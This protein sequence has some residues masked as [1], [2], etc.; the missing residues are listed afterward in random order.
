MILAML[1]ILVTPSAD[2]RLFNVASPQDLVK[3]SKLVFVGRVSSVR[4]SGIST[5]LS[6][7]PWEGVTFH[8]M[9]AEVEVLEPFKSVRKGETVRIAM[10]STDRDLINEPLMVFP[11]KGDVFLC[12]LLPTP[13]TNLFAALTAPY[14]ESLSVITLHRFRPPLEGTQSSAQASRTF[15]DKFLRDK[16]QFS[17]IFDL[18]DEEA[19]VIAASAE[20]F[21]RTF[22]AE[23]AAKSSTDKMYLEWETVVSKG[24]WRSDVPKGTLMSTGSNSPK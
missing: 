8:W 7:V 21:S 24:E 19:H 14:N 9:I 4:P 22:A 10:L 6:Y 11:E 3:K 20:R 15:N 16:K 1:A 17:S 2:G 23:L 5:S 18:V 13:V 12:C